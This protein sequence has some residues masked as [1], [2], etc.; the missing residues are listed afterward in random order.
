ME[1]CVY[2]SCFL[3][4]RA[5]VYYNGSKALLID[6]ICDEC[7]FNDLHNHNVKQ[8][9]V[10][11][12]HEH[13]DHLLGVERL[14]QE[15][16]CSV[17]CSDKA[18]ENL[19][20][21]RKNLSAYAEYLR[22]LFAE[23]K[24]QSNLDIPIHE[25]SC[26][27]DQ[28]FVGKYELKFENLRFNLVSTPGHSEG[29]ICV[30]QILGEKIERIFSGDTVLNDY[31]IYT[32]IPGGSKKLFSEI[33]KPFLLSLPGDVMVYPGHGSFMRLQDVYR[34]IEAK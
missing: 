32:K 27:G 10:I 29:S 21:P 24:K 15:F 6:T 2:E 1:F 22:Q 23:K 11:L 25:F 26:R 7:L 5:Y 12:T 20:N 33:T 4:N 16:K 31:P 18:F 30:L 8:V 28:T 9:Q 19:P 14:R 34:V 17:I 3:D 13:F